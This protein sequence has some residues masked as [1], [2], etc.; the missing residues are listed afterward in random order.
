MNRELDDRCI[1]YK[2]EISEKNLLF[3]NEVA[4]LSTFLMKRDDEIQ[5][6]KRQLRYISDQNL[7]KEDQIRELEMRANILEE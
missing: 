5:A 3:Q 4:E 7:Q 1:E 6:L 2:Q